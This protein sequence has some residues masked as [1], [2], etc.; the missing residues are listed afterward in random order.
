MGDAPVEIITVDTAADRTAF[1]R[2]P[3]R[4]HARDPAYVAPLMMQRRDLIDPLRNPYFRHADVRLFLARRDGRPVGRIAAQ[5]DHLAVETHGAIGHFGL[6]AAADGEIVA[7]LMAAAEGF[8]RS[9][10]MRLVRGPFNLSINHEAGLLVAGFDTPPS[11]MTPHDLP[12]LGLALSRLGYDKA[13]DLLGFSVPVDAPAPDFV[14]RVLGGLSARR[15]TIRPLD[16]ADYAGELSRALTVFNEAWRGNWGFV[17]LTADEMRAMADSLRPLLDSRLTAF[18][19]LDGEPA[20]M[21]IALPDLNEALRG[22]GGRLLPFGWAR[23]LWRL[24]LR[25][26]KGARVP[27]MGVRPK[28]AATALG[29]ALPFAMVESV[30]PRM[31]AL[32]YRRVEMSWVLEDNSPMCRMA[33]AMGGR[34]TKRWRLYERALA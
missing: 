27:L 3:D 2:L 22:L 25:G 9:Q 33:D 8:L 1:V 30:R 19:E 21:L 13:R 6:L 31:R 14:R 23:L 5:I 26:L 29:A 28:V 12:H 15:L 11:V 20:A 16:L 17:P 10:G 32:G 4:L 34:L 24:K 18:A 7:A